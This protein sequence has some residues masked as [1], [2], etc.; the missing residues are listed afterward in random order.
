MIV[1]IFKMRSRSYSGN[2]TFNPPVPKRSDL[3]NLINDQGKTVQEFVANNPG[4]INVDTAPCFLV[5][6]RG[7]LAKVAGQFGQTNFTA[8]DLSI[9]Y[10]RFS[11]G[12]KTDTMV[13]IAGSP[14]VKPQL[15]KSALWESLQLGSRN[16]VSPVDLIGLLVKK[17]EAVTKAFAK[18][19]VG[20]GY[21]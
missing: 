11:H 9:Y 19:S 18:G 21:F 1:K 2:F 17:D 14:G 4:D 5:G 12:T 7:S 16:S 8:N 20:I 13:C 3:A 10:T 6:G 15:P